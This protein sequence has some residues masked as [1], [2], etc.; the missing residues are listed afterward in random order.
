[1]YLLGKK[2]IKKFR[3]KQR[4]RLYADVVLDP[5]IIGGIRASRCSLGI[6]GSCSLSSSLSESFD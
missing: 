3:F 6:R 1:M 2:L 4:K 5:D